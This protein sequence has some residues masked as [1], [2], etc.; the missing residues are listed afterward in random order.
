MESQSTGLAMR[1]LRFLA[2]ELYEAASYG[3]VDTVQTLLDTCN[4][5]AIFDVYENYY[6]ANDGHI[7]RVHINTTSG[8]CT[9]IIIILIMAP[10]PFST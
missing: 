1:R 8:Y 3:K 2:L 6:T 10:F 5:S 4:D 9:S 7:V